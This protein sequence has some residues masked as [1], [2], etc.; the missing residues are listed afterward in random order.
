MEKQNKDE[1]YASFTMASHNEQ[2]IRDEFVQHFR[3]CPIPDDQI[4]CNL[5]MFI[6]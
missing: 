6:N 5:G 1:A 3:N 2:S 4:M